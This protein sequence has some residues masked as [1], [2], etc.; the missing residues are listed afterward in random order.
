M[1]NTDSGLFR[2]LRSS[3]TQD[4]WK[5]EGNVIRAKVTSVILPLYE[6][7]LLHQYDHRFATFEGRG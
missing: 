1:M 3:L 6:A 4:G 7:K 5:L 2:T